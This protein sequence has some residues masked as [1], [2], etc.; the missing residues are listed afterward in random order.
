[1]NAFLSRI[2]PTAI[3]YVSEQ[4]RLTHEAMGYRKQGGTV[5]PNGIDTELFTPS[6]SHRTGVRNELKLAPDTPLVGML[7][8]L[9]PDKDHRT[10]LEAAKLLHGRRTDLHF[11]LAGT[12]IVPQTPELATMIS[13]F[14]LEHRVHMLGCRRDAARIHA[15]L[16][17]EV[18]TTTAQEGFGLVVAEAMA[19]GVPC[20][21]TNS[22]ALP[23]VLDD[24]GFLVEERDAAAVARSC[25]A[26][27]ELS[28]DERVR[29]SQRA[30]QRVVT[31]FSLS[32]VADRYSELWRTL[33][34]RREVASGQSR[35]A[36]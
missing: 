10:F 18:L 30:R 25:L 27:L 9:H 26:L 14:G 35:R 24:V 3:V 13:Q 1:M 20:V 29:L 16:D 28:N 4:A 19:C 12:N 31:H 8:R 36:S 15:A 33:L 21:A 2:F 32:K 7:A 17:V 23:Q 5:I 6:E 11:V 22:G 34:C